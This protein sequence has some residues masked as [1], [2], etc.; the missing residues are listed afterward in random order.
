MTPVATDPPELTPIAIDGKAHRGSARRTVGRS[1][2]HVVSAWAV[3]HHLTLGQVATDAKSNEITAIPELLE[4]LD[5]NGAVVTIDAMGCQKEIAADIIGRGGQYVL[6]AK[7][8]QP[9]LYEDITRAFDEALDQGEPGVDFTECQTEEVRGGRQ[10]TRCCCVITDPRGIRGAGLWAGLTAIVMVI[11]HRVIDGVESI[12][13]RYFIGSMAGTA[14]QYLRWV[15]GHWG[16][17]NSL[18]WVLDVCFRED[19]QRHWAGNSAMNLAWLRKLALCLLKAETNSKGK[20]IATRRLLAGWKNDYLLRVLDQ[21]PEK[22]AQALPQVGRRS[23][24]RPIRSAARTVRPTSSSP[25]PCSSV[26]RPRPPGPTLRRGVVL[27]N[28]WFRVRPSAGRSAGARPSGVWL[29]TRCLPSPRRGSFPARS[30]GVGRGLPFDLPSGSRYPPNI[31][32]PFTLESMSGTGPR[33]PSS[34]PA[35]SRLQVG[36]LGATEGFGANDPAPSRRPAGGTPRLPSEKWFGKSAYA[37]RF[38]T[39]FEHRPCSANAWDYVVPRTGD[40]TAVR[41]ASLARGAPAAPR[42]P[43]S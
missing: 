21:I 25:S 32:A 16:I 26:T 27:T 12:E 28:M 24:P 38:G 41:H 19:D 2:L 3:E 31:L 43:T 42:R 5:L 15:R 37:N 35:G 4:L 8:N 30:E 14:E 36:C 20:S 10:E 17:E 34:R 40:P 11:S 39:G 6:A 33:V 29:S 23:C 13:I 1:A 7:E 22:P 18:H 9:H